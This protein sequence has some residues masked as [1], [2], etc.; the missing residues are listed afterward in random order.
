M[1]P[2]DEQMS[3]VE[4]FK[5]KQD[6]RINAFA[7]TGKTTTLTMLSRDTD[8]RGMYLAFNKSIAADAET[9]FPSNVTCSTVHSLAYRATPGEYKRGGKMTNRINANALAQ[10]LKLQDGVVGGHKLTARSQAHLILSTLRRFMHGDRDLIQN[11]DVPVLGRMRMLSD[12]DQ[13]SLV[14]FAVERARRVWDRMRD[15]ADS[16]PLGHDGYLK[17]WA[18]GKPRLAA[19][20][21]MLDEAQDTN[22]VVLGVLKAQPC[23]V[24]YVGDRHQQI[25]EWRG[26]IN[27]ME[28]INTPQ[29][30]YL[31]TSFRFGPEIAGAAS[32]VL[33]LLGEQR[34]LQGNANRKSYLAAEG[35]EAILARTNASVI[36]TVISKMAEGYAVHVIGGVDEIVRMLYAVG[37]L[38]R[39]KPSEVPEFFGFGHWNEVVEY[40][41]TDEGEELRTFVGLV[42]QHGEK[43]L[44]AVLKSTESSEHAADLVISTAHKAK[45]R[46][47]KT[48][49]LLDDFLKSRKAHEDGADDKQFDP[50]E[51]RLFYVALTRGQEAVKVSP[52]VLD[53]F[54]IKATSTRPGGPASTPSRKGLHT[55]SP[56]SPSLT[57]PISTRQ[58]SSRYNRDLKP[59]PAPAKSGLL[60]RYWW[61]I[62]LAALV[63]FLKS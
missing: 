14:G 37:D 55:N 49:E 35:C 20:F 23:Q 27:A 34:P 33:K 36:S 54:N 15:P 29:Q 59:E 17:L 48:V 39:G 2:T 40:S 4:A 53:M 32:N 9:K 7:G 22:P 11:E 58:L 57:D 26:A 18:L 63:Y 10:E 50:A 1:Q 31:T 60:E 8:R 28:K 13:E 24:V 62:L 19:D 12:L 21:I 38:K 6:L 51:V 47:W 42:E 43:R 25:Y 61:V 3:A 46:E 30:T 41:K 52:A 44:I 56:A 5:T 45:G 16:L